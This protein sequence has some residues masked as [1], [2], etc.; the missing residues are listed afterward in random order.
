[1]CMNVSAKLVSVTDLKRN[2]E[3][4]QVVGSVADIEDL[5]SHGTKSKWGT[6]VS[7]ADMV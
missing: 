7:S 1:M 2:T 5:V 4:R 3:A 6:F